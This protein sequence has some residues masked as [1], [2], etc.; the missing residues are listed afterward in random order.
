MA[1]IIEIHPQNPQARLIERAADVLQRGGVAI[2][3]TDSGYAMGCLVEQ[4]SALERIQ[5]IRQLPKDH[6]FTLL[7]RDLSHISQYARVDNIMFRYLKAHLPG[8]YT[9]LLPATKE[10]PKRLLHPKRRTI[11]LRVPDNIVIQAL[12]SAL[13]ESLMNVSLH[14]SDVAINEIN[15]LP[16]PILRQVDVVIDS[17]YLVPH[18]TTIVDFTSGEPVIVRP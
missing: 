11:G 14:V 10:V 5:Q 8:P 2:Y 3:P 6:L 13:P 7:C 9:I 4:K 16:E 17:G 15:D 18:P 12:L 1:N